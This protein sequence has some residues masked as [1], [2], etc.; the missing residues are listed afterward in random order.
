MFM[1]LHRLATF[2]ACVVLL[3]C[4]A[5]AS[6]DIP[7][8]SPATWAIQKATVYYRAGKY[9]LVVGIEDT[10]QGLAWASF[11]SSVNASG[12]AVLNLMTNANAEYVI[13]GSIIRVNA[14]F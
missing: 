5:V 11:N 4:C 12:W 1:M 2:S 3:V 13:N 10:K 14:R 7:V 6:A 8:S 9:D